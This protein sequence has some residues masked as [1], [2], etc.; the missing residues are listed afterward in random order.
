VTASPRADWLMGGYLDTFDGWEA[1]GWL[2]QA[3][4]FGRFLLQW[5]ASER[6]KRIVVPEAFWWMSILGSLCATAYAL[7]QHNLFFMAGPCI[8]FF[9]FVRNLWLSRTGQ[10]LSSRVL[11][12]FAL[13]VLTVAATAVFWSWDFSQSLPWTLVGGCGALLWSIRFPVQWWMAERR[14]Y[15][16]LP[17]PFFWIS[18]V[19]SCL[20]LAYA[21]RTGTP[22]FI[23][24]MV[25]GPLLYGRNLALCYRKSAGPS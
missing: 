7:V 3:C 6:A 24:G 17:P 19:G 18:F 20:L 13:G 22:V 9:L 11:A 15:V 21:L 25:L 8:N 16:T 12:P 10:P 23:A 1:I 5:I 4:Y 2:G 14:S